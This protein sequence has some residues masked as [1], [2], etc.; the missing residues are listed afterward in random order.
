VKRLFVVAALS[1][2]AT[3]AHAQVPM[4]TFSGSLGYTK[5]EDSNLEA[6]Q[7]RLSARF[8]PNFGIEGEGAL[9]TEPNTRIFPSVPQLTIKNQLRQELGVYAVGYLPVTSNAEV[10]ARIGYGNTWF[11]RTF[12]QAPNLAVTKFD[13]DSINLGVGGQYF[14]DGKNG[15]RVDYTRQDFS[16]GVRTEDSWA[17]AFTR[18]F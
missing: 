3:A 9:G 7:A 15:L 4:P 6:V 12:A 8:H 11:K 1:A 13:A 16:K 18:R 17:V 2:A 10:F 5:K 14:L